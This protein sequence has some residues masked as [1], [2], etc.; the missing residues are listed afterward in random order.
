MPR[1]YFHLHDDIDAPDEEGAEL[2]NVQVAREHAIHMVKVT[3]AET[4]KEHGRVA[5][6]TKLSCRLRKDEVHV[7]QS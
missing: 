6:K 3:F 1:F 5:N 7:G 2:P 4:V